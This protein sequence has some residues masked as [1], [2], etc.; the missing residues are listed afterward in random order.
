MF[1]MSDNR[2][3][4]VGL[5]GFGALFLLLGVMFLFDHALLALG[6]ILFLAGII[7]LIGAN[8]TVKFFFGRQDKL[9]GTICFLGGIFIVL[10]GWPMIGMLIEAFGI[11]NLFGLVTRFHAHH[12]H[13]KHSNFFPVVFA[14]VRNLPVVG[15]ILQHPVVQQ[16]ANKLMGETLPTHQSQN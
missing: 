11:L 13:T 16:L 5:T 8:R 2:K 4:G 3:I 7:L 6:N 12:S 15:P 10:I 14:V 1:D 9:R